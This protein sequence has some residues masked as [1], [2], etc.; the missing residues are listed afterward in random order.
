[1]PP[2]RTRAQMSLAHKPLHLIRI[3]RKIPAPATTQVACNS[4]RYEGRPRPNTCPDA[5]ISATMI[6][7]LCTLT[8]EM[9]FPGYLRPN[10]PRCLPIPSRARPDFTS[11]RHTMRT[12]HGIAPIASAI[13]KNGINPL[14]GSRSRTTSI[15]GMVSS[16]CGDASRSSS[17]RPNKKILFRQMT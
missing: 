2:A 3:L 13:S 10:E 9:R 5:L 16:G 8:D 1:M 12:S 11:R 15:N 4:P 14:L 7:F 17:Y 6:A